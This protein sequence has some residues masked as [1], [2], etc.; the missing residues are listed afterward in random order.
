M[1]FWHAMCSAPFLFLPS[2]VN[3]CMLKSLVPFAIALQAG[4]LYKAACVLRAASF[5][6]KVDYLSCKRDSGCRDL[7]EGQR[8]EEVRRCWRRCSRLYVECGL[9]RQMREKLVNYLFG[10]FLG[11]VS[12]R[13]EI[14]CQL[15]TPLA[16]P[17][18]QI[19]LIF[20][21]VKLAWGGT[22]T[23]GTW[24]A[25]QMRYA[26]FVTLTRFFKK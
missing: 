24:F 18:R 23:D 6:F 14:A 4:N 25:L 12:Y 3:S 11:H 13:E 26:F 22:M 17:L 19:F 9:A 21:P 20:D 16:G 15:W 10:G 1:A 2:P 8:A 7:W 5:S